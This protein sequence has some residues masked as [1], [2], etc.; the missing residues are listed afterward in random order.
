MWPVFLV[1]LGGAVGAVLRY[2][3]S[4]LVA[5]RWE[6]VLPMGTLVVN[7]IGSLLIAFFVVK[8]LESGAL[9]SDWRLLIVVG[10]GGAFTTFS[11]FSVETMS[12]LRDSAYQYAMF[13]VLVNVCL[14][15]LAAWMGFVLARIV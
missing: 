9:S 7:V 4:S 11:S 8:G 12:L 3:I 5:Y 2:S 13:N 10:L 6:S 15:L 14:C 1:A